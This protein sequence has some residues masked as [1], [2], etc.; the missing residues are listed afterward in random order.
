MKRKRKIWAIGLLLVI[1]ASFLVGIGVNASG[2]LHWFIKRCPGGTP[3]FPKESK[4]IKEY[5]AFYIDEKAK[6]DDKVIYITFDAGYENGNVEKILDI[7]K[8]EG[9][10]AAFFLLDNIILRNTDLVKRMADEGHLVCN[11]TKNHK[12]LSASSEEEIREDLSAL[13]DIYRKACGREMSKYFRFPEGSYSIDALKSVQRLGYKTI[14]WSF[15]YDDWDNGRQPNPERA[16]KKVLDNTHNGGVMLFHPTSSTNVEILPDLIHR[17]QE[18]GY[19]FG[20][21]DRLTSN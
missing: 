3:G 7:L 9:V 4:Q 2:S 1:L 13:E 8:N 5:G 19:S 17:W 15:A 10:P 14:F 21:L 16:M 12:N 11:H 20:T 18:M 6:D